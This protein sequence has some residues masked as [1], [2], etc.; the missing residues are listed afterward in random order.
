V[1]N[2][3][4]LRDRRVDHV[5]ARNRK[6]Q[7]LGWFRYYFDESRCVWSTQV[8]R[9]HGYAPGAPVPGIELALSHV[10][11]D[12]YR[13]VAATFDHVRRTPQ[14]FSSRHR[15]VDIHSRV[16][17]VTVIATPFHNANG[18]P[19]GVQGVCVELAPKT[20]T[21]AVVRQYGYDRLTDQ[22]RARAEAGHDVERRRQIR[23]AT[24]C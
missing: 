13:R 18:T 8:L 10:H 7:R 14:P 20:S 3:T 2:A 1:N 9:M 12:D 4:R 17:D 6:P 16:H 22:L 21:T 23:A 5:A 24:R 15:I 19:V 11:P